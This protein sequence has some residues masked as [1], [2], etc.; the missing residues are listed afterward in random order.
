MKT[1]KRMII[2]LAIIMLIAQFS[3]IM[4]SRVYAA[5]SIYDVI[6]SVNNE[7]EL[8][9]KE[10]NDVLANYSFTKERATTDTAF[11]TEIVAANNKVNELYAGDEFEVN[12]NI[13]NFTNIEKG[14]IS[15]VGQLEYDTNVLEKVSITRNENQWNPITINENN[16]KFVIDA[17]NYVTNPGNVLKIKF[18]VKSNVT[19]AT[20]TAIKV[21]NIEACIGIMDFLSADAELSV[22]IKKRPDAISS[23]KYLVEQ[24]T[25]S[26]IAP[27]TTVATFKKNVSTYQ[28]IIVK[29]KNGNLLNDNAIVATGTKIQVGETLKMT[30]VVTG[31]TDGD[32]QIGMTDL[33]KVKMHYIEKE[34]LTGIEL[35]AAD[36]DGNNDITVTDLAQI[37]LV[38]VDLMVIE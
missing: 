19:T 28:N 2:S 38:L 29:D 27:G 7:S 1:T 3:F 16:L 13:K 23:D 33:A 20:T 8:N 18:R 21:K 6:R 34:L 17:E 5:E 12:V 26:R 15:L 31:D 35:K 25:I 30:L 4:F 14:L 32:G 37:K 9:Q 22:N 36:V 11:D 24:T 10:N